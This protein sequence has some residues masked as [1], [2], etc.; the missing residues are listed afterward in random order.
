[1]EG[2]KMSTLQ[3]RS[4]LEIAALTGQRHNHILHRIKSLI[5]KGV[6][7][8]YDFALSNYVDKKAKLRQMY[9]LDCEDCIINLIE[10]N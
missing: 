6:I 10:E 3:K 2:F 8:Q 9:V 7:G 1:M 5:K 4:S